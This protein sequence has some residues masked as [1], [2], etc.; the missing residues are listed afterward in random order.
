MASNP[1]VAKTERSVVSTSSFPAKSSLDAIAKYLR[2]IRATGKLV[3]N[4]S[5]GGT[6][7]VT[8]EARH[9]LNGD[10]HVELIFEGD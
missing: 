8:F 2:T 1:Q 9:V 6:N 3:V 4:F 10:D 7:S 5:Q